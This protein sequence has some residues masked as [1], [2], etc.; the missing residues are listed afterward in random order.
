MS[1]TIHESNEGHS[2]GGAGSAGGSESSLMSVRAVAWYLL[3]AVGIGVVLLSIPVIAGLPIE[4]FILAGTY[5][6]LLGGAI[7]AVRRSGG[8]VRQLFRGA[9]RWRFGWLRWVFVLAA[10]PVTAIAVATIT[11]TLVA[12]PDGWMATTG[13]YLIATLL[14][15][16]LVINMWEE[17]AWQ[18]LVQRSLTG[19]FGPVRAAVL[20]GIPFALL[21]VPLSFADDAPMNEALV[22]TLVLF[23]LAPP[24]RYLLGWTDRITGESLLAVAVLHASFNATGALDVL[25]GGWQHI[26]AVLLVTSIVAISG[27]AGRVGWRGRPPQPVV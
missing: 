6:V 22:A 10:L 8:E 11:G 14:L 19:H 27:W 18:G 4:P 15:G 20:T 1:E 7:I 26:A 23:V 12:P 16:T 21:H 13:G 3:L 2:A 25:E 9:L 17:T 5:F 24:F